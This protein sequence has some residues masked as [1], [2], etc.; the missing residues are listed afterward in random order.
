MSGKQHTFHGHVNENRSET[1]FI[2]I[3]MSISMILVYLTCITRLYGIS[4]DCP[5]VM[6]F[7]QGLNLHLT[8]PYFYKKVPIDCC[9][10]S[11]VWKLG[12][13]GIQCTGDV[14]T[15]IYM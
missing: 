12:E 15:Y 11:I 4:P 8:D 14:V 2:F 1:F 9:Q 13:L 3:E 10:T 5:L 6:K 7:L